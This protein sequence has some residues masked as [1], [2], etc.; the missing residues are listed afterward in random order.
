[1]HHVQIS[2]VKLVSES[3]PV[4]DQATCPNPLMCQFVVLYQATVRLCFKFG[5][6]TS[7]RYFFASMLI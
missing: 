1:M 7:T 3:L 2:E 5:S 4:H 6:L